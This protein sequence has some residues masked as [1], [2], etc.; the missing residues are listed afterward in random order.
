MP[1]IVFYWVTTQ[2]CYYRKNKGKENSN[3]LISF[4]TW[5]ETQGKVYIVH[6]KRAWQ[7]LDE[8]WLEL[9]WQV[10][11]LGLELKE[12]ISK[13]PSS[14]STTSGTPW[15]LKKLVNV[16]VNEHKHKHTNAQGE[17]EDHFVLVVSLSPSRLRLREITWLIPYYTIRG[18]STRNSQGS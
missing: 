7:H 6:E 17:D 4:R 10:I 16:C 2:A 11:T 5:R 8:A 3:P 15:E 1:S 9:C 18:R 14:T 13:I 12:V